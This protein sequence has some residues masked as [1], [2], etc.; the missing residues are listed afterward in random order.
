MLDFLLWVQEYGPVVFAA[1][2]GAVFA[3]F[4]CV[5]V[6]RVPRGESI[7]GFSHCACGRPL[8]PYE[9]IPVLGWL[10]TGG[11]AK[12][13]GARIPAHY[14]VAEAIS[15]ALWGVL[16][17]ALGFALGLAAAAVL[18]AVVTTVVTRRRIAA[19]RAA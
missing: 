12:C 18:T 2:L 3:S 17:L 6:E 19:S 15:A 13:C 16:V 14:V 7:N 4:C 11:K 10:R 5:V 8:K 9:N 1:L